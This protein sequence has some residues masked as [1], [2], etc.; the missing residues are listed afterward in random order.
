MNQ[1]PLDHARFGV[2][3]LNV[4]IANFEDIM[5]TEGATRSPAVVQSQERTLDSMR[6][7]KQDLINHVNNNSPTLQAVSSLN[8]N[9]NNNN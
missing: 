8:N 6:R 7:F 3:R 1:M 5:E 2:S 9:N 4:V